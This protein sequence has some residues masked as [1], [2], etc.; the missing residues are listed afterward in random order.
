LAKPVAFIDNV[1]NDTILHLGDGPGHCRLPLGGPRDQG[2]A[3]V[4]NVP[5][6]GVPGQSAQSASSSE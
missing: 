2:V 1:G 5:W 4:G 6:R 3:E